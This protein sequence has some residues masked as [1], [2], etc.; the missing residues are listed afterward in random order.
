MGAGKD[1]PPYHGVPPDIQ[2]GFT[3]VRHPVS[4]L[5]SIYAYRTLH[6][7]KILRDGRNRL[8]HVNYWPPIIGLTQWMAKLS[9]AEFVDRLDFDMVSC[10]YGMYRHPNVRIYQLENADKLLDELGIPG[11][12]PIT[13]AT[14]GKPEVTDEQREKLE[15]VCRQSIKDYGY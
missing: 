14:P 8:D 3:I 5:R 13:H 9:W 15:R 12:L 6:K 10:V 7:W 1:E 11:P 2:D 4:W